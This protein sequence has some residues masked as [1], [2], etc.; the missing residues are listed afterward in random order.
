M[1]MSSEIET[2]CSP[3]TYWSWIAHVM[4]FDTTNIL[5]GGWELKEHFKKD[6]DHQQK[7]Q[8]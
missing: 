6:K 8:K 4:Y 2:L 7:P 5:K 1:K 3:L